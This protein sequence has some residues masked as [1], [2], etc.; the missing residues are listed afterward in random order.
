MP[1]IAL[2]HSHVSSWVIGLILFGLAVLFLKSGK[3]KPLKITQMV[4][5]LFY[6]LILVTGVALLFQ[7]GFAAF[8]VVKG[9]LAF[10][11]IYFMEMILVRGAKRTLDAKTERTYWIAF[12]VLLIAVIVLGYGKFF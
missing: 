4:L 12:F 9:I 11:L 6:I 7:I 3:A 1:Y 2:L 10:I 8:A 5:R